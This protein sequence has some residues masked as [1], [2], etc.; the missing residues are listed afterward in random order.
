[1][2]DNNGDAAVVVEKAKKK[3]RNELNQPLLDNLV[4]LSNDVRYQ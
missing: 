3:A 2:D 4:K 1:M